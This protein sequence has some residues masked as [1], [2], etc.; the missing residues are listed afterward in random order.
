MNSQPNIIISCAITGAIHTHD[1]V[2]VLASHPRTD[3]RTIDRGSSRR[4]SDCAPARTGS[5]RWPTHTRSRRVSAICATNQRSYR[6]GDQHNH[7][8]RTWHDVEQR[9][10]AAMSLEPEMCSLNMGSMNLVYS[11]YFP[12]IKRGNM[13]GNQNILKTQGITSLRTRSRISKRSSFSW[14]RVAEHGLSSSATM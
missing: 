13:T 3:R 14:A 11:N 6:C 5:K 4:R 1:N 2:P 12:A 9:L 10:A 8:W 7:R